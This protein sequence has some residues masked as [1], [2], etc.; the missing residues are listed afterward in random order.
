MTWKKAGLYVIAQF[1]GAI[2]GAAINVMVYDG[3][4]KAFERKHNIVRGEPMS[5]LTASA[6]GE[7]FP[8]PG[9]NSLYGGGPYEQDD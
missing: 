4:F 7:Y 1:A 5:I 2:I 8:N 3:T 6:F 9:L